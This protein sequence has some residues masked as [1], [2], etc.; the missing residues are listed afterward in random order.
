MAKMIEA[1]AYLRTSSASNLDGDSEDRQK[2]A[3]EA[4]AKLNN[5]K[6]VGEFWDQAV[7]GADDIGD[8]P[9]FNAMMDRIEGNGVRVVIVESA[10]RL[11]R[12]VIAQELAVVAMEAK[13]IQIL[14]SSGQNLTESDDPAKVAMRQMAGVFSQYEKQRLVNKLAAARKRFRDEG[15]KVEGRKSL[16]ETNPML[17]KRVRE[18][19][20]KPRNSGTNRTWYKIAKMLADKGFVNSKGNPYQPHQIKKLHAA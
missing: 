10:D 11:A 4:F 17:L 20:R 15:K 1:L 19:R 7:S 13:G 8:R 18:L 3:I 6:I 2:R 5:Y 16:N 12:S 14:T 9:Q